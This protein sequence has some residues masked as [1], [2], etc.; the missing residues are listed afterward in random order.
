M[1]TGGVRLCSQLVEECVKHSH[2][3]LHLSI[4][5][6][7]HSRAVVQGQILLL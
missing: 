6:R 7:R 5:F 3:L 1:I 2:R 4:H